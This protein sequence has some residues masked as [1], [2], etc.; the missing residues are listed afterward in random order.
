MLC[1]NNISC[2]AVLL[3]YVVT[4][5]SGNVQGLSQVY[6]LLL[7][8]CIRLL[9]IVDVLGVINNC[10]NFKKIYLQFFF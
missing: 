9:Y 3:Q 4:H 5:M 1:H 7:V 8:P 2:H 10:A 6:C